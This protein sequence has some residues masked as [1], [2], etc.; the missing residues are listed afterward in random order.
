M[1]CRHDYCTKI[2]NNDKTLT[3][4]RDH[5]FPLVWFTSANALILLNCSLKKHFF[6]GLSL[7]SK[8]YFAWIFAVID[9]MKSELHLD[10][11]KDSVTE[12]EPPPAAS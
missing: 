11:D 8:V 12:I 10:T 9:K 7:T 4:K 5:A 2:R 1:T 6:G 3:S